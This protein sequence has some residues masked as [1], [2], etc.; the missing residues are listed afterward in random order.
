MTQIAIVLVVATIFIDLWTLISTFDRE[1]GLIGETKIPMQELEP[2]VQGEIIV[3]LY[4]RNVHCMAGYWKH[5]KVMVCRKMR[6]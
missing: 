1:G 3:G 6:D 2:K 5:S 4:G